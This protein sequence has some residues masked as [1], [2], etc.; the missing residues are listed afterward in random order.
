M[1]TSRRKVKFIATLMITIF[2]FQFFTTL[3]QTGIGHTPKECEKLL[4]QF[5]KKRQK[6]TELNTKLKELENDQAWTI[7]KEVIREATLAG[8]LTGGLGWILLKEKLKNAF[9]KAGLF[10]FTYNGIKALIDSYRETE[11]EIERVRQKRDEK[12]REALELWKRYLECMKHDHPTGSLSPYMN[13]P[14]TVK[15][16]DSHTALFQASVAYDRVYWYV[17]AP[18]QSGYGTNVS[19]EEGDGSKLSS[20]LCF[21]APHTTGTYTI[22]AYVY[23]SDT[24]I[25]NSYDIVVITP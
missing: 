7:I 6:A 25:E 15:Y 13:T 1:I 20:T 4:K 14:T 19:T 23:F 18:D 8:L 24:I 3:I 2:L 11:A 17:R 12:N 22:T 5:E 10:G 16:G 21:T 9:R